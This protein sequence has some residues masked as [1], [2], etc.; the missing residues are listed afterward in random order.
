MENQDIMKSKLKTNSEQKT[1]YKT[2]VV[3]TQ[4]R[5]GSS[6]LSGVLHKLGVPMGIDEKELQHT[7]D[8]N[9]W[10][11][12]E[13]LEIVRLSE[14]I[15]KY[16][17]DNPQVSFARLEVEFEDRIKEV[18][19]SRNNNDIWGYKDVNQLQTLRMFR[20]HLRNPHII[21]LLR[22]PLDIALSLQDWR[23]K[24]QKVDVHIYQ[25]LDAVFSQYSLLMQ[26]LK[27][28]SNRVLLMSYERMKED[29]DKAVKDII[30]FLELTP[31]E[32]QIKDAK[33]HIKA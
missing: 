32:E 17:R 20:K 5:S 2:A 25:C 27:S 24:Y 12:W 15:I 7:S 6:M 4:R 3:L 18:I 9:E 8:R 13:D 33:D 31:T 14:D 30:D 21:G 16:T 10:G 22:N 23:K 19:D 26:N 28:M 1:E 11:F 29:P